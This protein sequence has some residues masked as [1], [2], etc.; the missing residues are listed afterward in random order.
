MGAS[1][2][3]KPFCALQSRAAHEPLYGTGRETA[4]WLLLEVDRPWKRKAVKNNRLPAPVQERLACWAASTPRARVQFIRKEVGTRREPNA[5]QLYAVA[6]RPGQAALFRTRLAAYEALADLD[7]SFVATG[8]M[9][10]DDRWHSSDERLVLTCVHGKRDRCCAKWGRP[11]HRAFERAPSVTAW[12]T[13]HLG[14][15]RFAPTT[16]VLPDGIHYGRLR[17]G[18]AAPLV[19]AHRR[20]CIYRLDRLRGEVV[21]VRPVQAAA[22]FLRRELGIR[23]INALRLVASDEEA[24]RWRVT[25][26]IEGTDAIEGTRAIEDARYQVALAIESVT[27]TYPKSCG[28]TPGASIPRYRIEGITK[29]AG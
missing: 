17:P 9:P 24:D 1:R 19:E 6:V 25:F 18:D 15:H 27:A 7:L 8:T 22:Y 23:A 16:L 21:F 3:T 12:Q 20:G 11:V 14:G 29:Q 5:I 13:T 26:S 28:D 10:S 2:D 4:H